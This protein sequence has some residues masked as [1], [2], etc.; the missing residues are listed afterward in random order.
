M[1]AGEARSDAAVAVVDYGAGN[2]RSLINALEHLGAEVELVAD[3]AALER[4]SPARLIVPGVGAFGEAMAALRARGL[5]EPLKAHVGRGGHFLGIC[6]GFQ[7]LFEASEEHGHHEG[8]GIIPGVVARFGPE[9]E[10]VPHMGWN[11]VCRPVGGPPAHPLWAGYPEAHVYFVHSYRVASVPE[12]WCARTT[13]YGPERFV[14]AVAREAVVGM[15]FH[16]E[17]SGAWGLELLERWLAWS[18]AVPSDA[19][20]ERGA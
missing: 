7:L 18:G 17:R 10:I 8:L 13:T 12:T 14:A 3:G 19:E 20:P 11:T 2:L 5:V 16:P 4:L 1:S 9:V 15:Q 6:L